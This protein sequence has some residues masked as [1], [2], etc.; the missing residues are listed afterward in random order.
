MPFIERRG[1]LYAKCDAC[2]FTSR[3]PRDDDEDVPTGWGGD[4]HYLRCVSCDIEC[5]EV[6]SERYAV[7]NDY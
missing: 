2:G 1:R 4:K 6:E 7:L 5:Q 3:Y